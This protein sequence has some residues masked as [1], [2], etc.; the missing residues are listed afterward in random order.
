MKWNRKIGKAGKPEHADR[1]F[2][3]LFPAFLF[4]QS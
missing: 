2:F 3:P 1:D 4:K